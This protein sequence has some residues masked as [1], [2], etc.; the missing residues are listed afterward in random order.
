MEQ[1]DRKKERSLLSLEDLITQAYQQMEDVGYSQT[2]CAHHRC[3]WRRLARLE[4][5]ECYS[6]E[7]VD[8]F[9]ISEG[10]PKICTGMIAR[11]LSVM[12]SSI[13]SG[14]IL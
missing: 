14:S 2:T 4:N 9:F 11:V 1:E 13:R 12:A 5:G 10:I 6:R 7:L 8:R 3:V